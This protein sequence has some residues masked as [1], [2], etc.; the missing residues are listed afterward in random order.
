MKHKQDLLETGAEAY[1]DSSG[2]AGTAVLHRCRC[3]RLL[4]ES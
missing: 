3:P 4:S 1:A 2:L